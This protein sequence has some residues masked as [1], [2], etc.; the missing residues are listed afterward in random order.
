MK[1]RA[2]GISQP[3]P[4]RLRI[5]HAQDSPIRIRPPRISR[6]LA[7]LGLG[8]RDEDSSPPIYVFRI[9]TSGLRD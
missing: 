2:F 6:R 4:W 3:G 1:I 9:R 8:L 5:R 7:F